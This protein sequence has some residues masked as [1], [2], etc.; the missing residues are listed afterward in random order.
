MADHRSQ[1]DV[2]D[3]KA[4]MDDTGPAVKKCL[5]EAGA[6]HQSSSTGSFL[7]PRNPAL[8]KALSTIRISSRPRI[9]PGEP[10]AASISS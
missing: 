10:Q 9:I 8:S 3:L 5:G 7:I 6:D 2:Q 4:A 1:P